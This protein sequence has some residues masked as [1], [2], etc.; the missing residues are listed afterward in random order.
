MFN[1][2]DETMKRTF[3]TKR[4]IRN[5]NAALSVGLG[6]A[7]LCGVASFSP[8]TTFAQEVESQ[9]KPSTTASLTPKAAEWRLFEIDFENAMKASDYRKAIEI[10]RAAEEKYPNESALHN[11]WRGRIDAHILAGDWDEAEEAGKAY[12]AFVYGDTKEAEANWALSDEYAV[13]MF[14][15][16]KRREAFEAA[17]RRASVYMSVKEA[18]VHYAITFGGEVVRPRNKY[19]QEEE[20]KQGRV[21]FMSREWVDAFAAFVAFAEEEFEKLGKPEACAEHIRF[22]RNLLENEQ[23]RLEADERD[24]EIRKKRRKAFERLAA[25]PPYKPRRERIVPNLDE[26]KVFGATQARGDQFLLAS[27]NV[28]RH[29]EALSQ[30]RYDEVC[31]HLGEALADTAADFWNLSEE[32]KLGSDFPKTAAQNRKSWILTLAVACE[33]DG[34]FNRAKTYYELVLAP[35]VLL[36]ALARVEYAKSNDAAIWPLLGKWWVGFDP[37]SSARPFH[38][39][40]A[41]P[42]YEA[43]E[44]LVERAK[45]R[46]E[47]EARRDVVWAEGEGGLPD[48]TWLEVEQIRWLGAS[49]VCPELFYSTTGATP[50]DAFA[51]LRTLRNEKYAEFVALLETEFAKLPETDG[52]KLSPRLRGTVRPATQETYAPT[53]RYL[54]K[55]AELP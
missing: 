43:L 9:E 1:E 31:K 4:Q 30:G 39:P 20:F 15:Q 19:L 26:G 23:K 6:I 8:Q 10:A 48:E 33:L 11:V 46:S 28:F 2:G 45:N 55:I 32:P 36:W 42:S 5:G 35:D 16:G 49:V 41:P 12:Y 29:G 51:K 44:K 25:R 24:V 37:R 14:G 54:K 50:E 3:L 47:E 22:F 52:S 18:Q 27:A 21:Y 13:V 34:R 17:C 40:A 7:T 53:L 38:Y